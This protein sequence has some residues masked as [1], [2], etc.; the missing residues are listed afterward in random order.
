[1][2]L[3]LAG[4]SRSGGA[5]DEGGLGPALAVGLAGRFVYRAR[6]VGPSPV[7]LVFLE[8]PDCRWWS[9]RVVL[10]GA[11]APVADSESRYCAVDGDALPGGLG[12]WWSLGRRSGRTVR[13][14]DVVPAPTASALVH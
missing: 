7:G 6:G 14:G 3:F 10:D 9:W 13:Y 1:V 8:W 5:G 12:R 11:G 4:L 2:P